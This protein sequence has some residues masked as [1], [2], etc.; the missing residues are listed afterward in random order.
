MLHHA[1]LSGRAALVPILL[2]LGATPDARDH[3]GLTPLHGA[4]SVG[5][6]ETIRSLVKAGGDVNATAAGADGATP[7]LMA[8]REQRFGAV[9]ALLLL[10]AR[11]HLVLHT[12]GATALHEAAADG[13]IRIA[14]LLLDAGALLAAADSRGYQP[15]HVAAEAGQ[16][17]AVTW[18]LECGA[19][20][21]A[22]AAEG[23]LP[24]HVAARC[25]DAA[26]I[27]ALVQ[28]DATLANARHPASDHT[29]LHFAAAGNHAPAINALLAAGADAAAADAGGSTPADVAAGAGALEAMHA[30]QQ[31]AAADAAAVDAD[32]GGAAPAD[33][34]A[35]ADA[36]EA[37]HAHALQQGAAADAAAADAGG[38]V[39]GEAAAGAGALEALP[40]LQ[41]GAA[42][43]NWEVVA[44]TI[45]E[46][47]CGRW[48]GVA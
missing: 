35:G 44:H 33:T 9:R 31:G 38:A 12:S 18:L 25:G 16:A 40:E 13:S 21:G 15:L 37:L 2:G 41:Q 36:V 23:D 19:D 1:A 4:A 27:V 7:L 26:C 34:A 10:G 42:A 46:L 20:A 5:C 22:F 24:I 30:L 8:V 45:P 3:R 11:V 28:S 39:P 43:D 6:V 32:A 48:H 17:D 29:P 47:H 14:E